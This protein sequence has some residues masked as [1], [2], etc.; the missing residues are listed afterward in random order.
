MHR[1]TGQHTDLVRPA[2]ALQTVLVITIGVVLL[3]LA[4]VV[5]SG[6]G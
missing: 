6:L 4:E 1:E 5:R 2:R 3:L